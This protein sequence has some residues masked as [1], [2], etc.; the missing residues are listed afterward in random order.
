MDA[1]EQR[2]DQERD[3]SERLR[4]LCA[5][6]SSS[7]SASSLN[8]RNKEGLCEIDSYSPCVNDDDRY[9]DDD[10]ALYSFSLSSRDFIAFTPDVDRTVYQRSID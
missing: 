10:Q 4:Q 1:I 3:Q 9:D 7:S 8:N 2:E 5:D 6:D